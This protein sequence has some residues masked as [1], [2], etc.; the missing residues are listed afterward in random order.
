VTGDIYNVQNRLENVNKRI[1]SSQRITPRNR[2]LIWNFC[3]HCRLQ[4]LSVLRV[5]FYLNR[6][7]NIARLATKNF[8]E[9]TKEDV[10]RLVT[11]IRDLRKRNGEPVSGRTVADHLVAIKTFW[12]ARPHRVSQRG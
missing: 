11:G 2:E 6:F 12:G 8:D 7:W 4:G 9:M 3:D 10:Q 5:V 1:V